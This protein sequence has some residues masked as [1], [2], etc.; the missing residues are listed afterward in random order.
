MT[1][2]DDGWV[3]RGERRSRR[4]NRALAA[5]GWLQRDIAARRC[6]VGLV[7]KVVQKQRRA[8]GAS[9]TTVH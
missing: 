9:P 7:N 6:S 3:R 5:E 2:G 1:I 8:E 4:A